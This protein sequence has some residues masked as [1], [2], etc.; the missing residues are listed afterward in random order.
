MFKSFTVLTWL[1]ILWTCTGIYYN[2]TDAGTVKTMGAFVTAN[3]FIAV[4][5]GVN[6]IRREIAKAKPEITI[7]NRGFIP[8]TKPHREEEN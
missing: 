4:G 6:L 1:A 2:I 7:V 5:L 8:A 3:V